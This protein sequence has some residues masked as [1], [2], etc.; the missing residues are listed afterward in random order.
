MWQFKVL[1]VI[2]L[3]QKIDF[4]SFKDAK[5]V[6]KRIHASRVRERPFYISNR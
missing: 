1:F 2:V 6:G 4:H 5:A 3:F